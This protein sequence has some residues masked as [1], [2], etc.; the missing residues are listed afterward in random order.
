MSDEELDEFTK[1]IE[2]RKECKVIYLGH[3]VLPNNEKE[4]LF[5]EHKIKVNI[6]PDYYYKEFRK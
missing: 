1:N 2:Q 5:K 3:D 4:A 6:I